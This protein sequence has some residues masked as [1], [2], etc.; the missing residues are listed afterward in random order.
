MEEPDDASRVIELRD[1]RASEWER[2]RLHWASAHSRQRLLL[3]GVTAVAPTVV[4]SAV[5]LPVGIALAVGIVV[6]IVSALPFLNVFRLPPLTLRF[7]GDGTF[8]V[9]SGPIVRR[10]DFNAVRE[11]VEVDGVGLLVR[12]P[13]MNVI[14]P[15]RTITAEQRD[16]LRA[17]ADRG[18]RR[19]AAGGVARW[20]MIDWASPNI[21]MPHRPSG[22][23]ALRVGFLIVAALSLATYALLR[24]RGS[25]IPTEKVIESISVSVAIPLLVGLALV[26]VE[27]ART[28]GAPATQSC[29]VLDDVMR[30]STESGATDISPRGVMSVTRTSGGIDIRHHGG[31]LC[32]PRGAFRDRS[33]RDE[34]AAALRRLRDGIAAG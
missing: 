31:L 12:A 10:S 20:T 24:T 4:V 13:A 1:A 8:E 17:L 11:F 25:T 33:H 9:E 5:G 18:A 27:L 15:Q 26:A 3:V 2:L 14:I 29:S 34:F 19:R 28:R 7:R 30:L 23:P 16:A 6:L 32:L 22:R 21:T